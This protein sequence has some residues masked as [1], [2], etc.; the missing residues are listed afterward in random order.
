V[1]VRKP[2][3]PVPGDFDGVEVEIQRHYG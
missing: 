2:H 1:R 3:P